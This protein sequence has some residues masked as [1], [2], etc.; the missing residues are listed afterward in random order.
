MRFA[1]PKVTRALRVNT[2]KRFL[3]RDNFFC[4]ATYAF[5]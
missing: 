1:G 3:L 4:A 2:D 5:R